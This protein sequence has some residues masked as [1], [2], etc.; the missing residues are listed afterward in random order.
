MKKQNMANLP[1]PESMAKLNAAARELTARQFMQFGY[2]F[3]QDTG[4]DAYYRWLADTRLADITLINVGS[5]YKK[6][7]DML[8]TDEFERDSIDFF[9]SHFGFENDHWGVIS[10]GGTD[11][12]MHGLYFGRRWLSANSPIPPILYVSDEAHYSVKKLG[13]VLNIETRAIS[14]LPMGQMDPDDFRRKLDPSRP[15]LVAIAIGGTFKGAIDD[16]VS[17]SEILSDLKPPLVYR[18]LDAALFGGYLPFLDDQKAKSILNA[19]E[20][21]F[22]SVAIS[23]HK[24]ISLNE[25][26]G[27]FICKSKI[28]KAV[29]SSPVPYLNGVI[30]TISC[31]RSG[32]DALKLYWR[33]KS[34]GA[35]GIREEARHAL[36]MADLLKEKLL[37]AGVKAWKNPYSNTVFFSRAPERVIHK[38]ALACNDDPNF[39]PLSHVVVMQYFT[40]DIIESFVGDILAG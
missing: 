15:A 16:Q 22:D 17:I 27:I 23:G 12:N 29:E 11:G 35:E 31:S 34:I 1:D 18:H 25:P 40:P 2:P 21:G 13:D 5:P 14:A 36:A 26:A 20:M 32:F 30:P 19:K 8:N 4:L 33:I 9:A 28:L 37:Q 39:G 38:Y 24:F 10:N 7:W 6:N 3:D